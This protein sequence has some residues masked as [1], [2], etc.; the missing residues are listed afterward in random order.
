M[1]NLRPSEMGKRREPT[2][3]IPDGKPLTVPELAEWL[4]VSRRYLNY[5]M[6]SGNLRRIVFG[7]HVVR[8]M[9]ADINSWLN[10]KA[11]KM[12]ARQQK[13]GRSSANRT[14]QIVEVGKKT[15]DGQM[16]P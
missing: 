16:V 15:N 5:E 10:S 13:E 1:K 7:K 11:E 14:G 3:F 9:P 8:L 12:A 4:S 6:A 2:S